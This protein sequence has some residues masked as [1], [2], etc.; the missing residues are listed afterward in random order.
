ME[1]D[2]IGSILVQ[3]RKE[4]RDQYMFLWHLLEAKDRISLCNYCT[5]RIE[6]ICGKTLGRDGVFYD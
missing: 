1:K 4:G 2:R 5:I 3:A 6:N